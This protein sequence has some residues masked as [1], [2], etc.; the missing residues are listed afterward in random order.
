MGVRSILKFPIVYETYQRLVGGMHM[1]DECLKVLDLKTGQRVLDVGCGPAYYLAQM[2]DVEYFG[3]D[4]DERYIEH[5]RKKFGARGNFR[6]AMFTPQVAAELGQFDRIMLMGILHHLDDDQCDELL[7]LLASV[8][9]PGGMIVALETVIHER[10]NP[11]ERML[12]EGDRGEYVRKPEGF[13]ALA[14]KH[15][16]SVD[17]QLSQEFWIPSIFW[18]MTM[19]Q[20]HAPD[21]ERAG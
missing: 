21:S 19:G 13:S 9:A 12:A 5:A 20:P 11:V 3:F 6:C 14:Q 4:T 2:P 16:Q 18:V 1:R 10:Q 15:F 7:A 8:L 17:G